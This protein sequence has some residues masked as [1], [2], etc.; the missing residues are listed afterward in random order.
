MSDTEANGQVRKPATTLGRILAIAGVTVLVCIAICAT[1]LFIHIRKHP[2]Y[3]SRD[4]PWIEGKAIMSTIS[5]AIK[6]YAAENEGVTIEQFPTDFESLGL[7]PADLESS[8]LARG[9]RDRAYFRE[10]MF[11]FTI[12]NTNPL[13]FRITCVNYGLDLTALT[14]DQ[15][16]KWTQKIIEDAGRL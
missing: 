5:T 11:S 2:P 10:Q 3:I 13:E 14:L 8:R 6:V 4:A 16:G 1:V 7:V 9:L 15:D 12:T